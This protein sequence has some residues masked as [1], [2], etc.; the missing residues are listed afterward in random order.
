[1]RIAFVNATHI[2]SGV[3]T[4]CL[5]NAEIFADKGHSVVLYGRPGA[6]VDKARQKGLDAVACSFG[7]DFNPLAI[8]FFYREFKRRKIELCVCNVSKDMHSAGIAAKLLGIPIVQHL[9]AAGDMRKSKRKFA[10]VQLLKPY[11]ITPSE[12]VKKGLLAKIPA[13]ANYEIMP[14]HP[15]CP[16]A[17]ECRK[18]VNSP[19]VLTITSRL[20]PGKGHEAI[21]NACAALKAEGF[22]FRCSIVGSGELEQQIRSLCINKDLD[23]IVSFGGFVTNIPEHLAASDIY[24]FPAKNEG[25]GI[26]LE[27]AIASG[28]PCIAKLGSGPDEIWPDERRSMLIPE[29]DEGEELCRQ[30]RRLLEMDDAA[31][32]EEGRIFHNHAEKHC[33]KLIQAEKLER[34]FESILKRR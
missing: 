30:I 28:M 2:W 26:A 29:D 15:G 7:A 1:M 16:V 32:L 27:E 34:W 19:R 33:N 10:T 12:F 9:G 31:L 4:W 8:W 3:K 17:P 18:K 5:D 25:L 14:I 22:D 6:F 24:L 20:A 21:L 13:L 23:D 11:F